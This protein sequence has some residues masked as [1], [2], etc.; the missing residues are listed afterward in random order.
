MAL[1]RG[2]SDCGTYELQC[3]YISYRSAVLLKYLCFFIP[4]LWSCVSYLLAAI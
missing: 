3:S 2:S 4:M 1:S